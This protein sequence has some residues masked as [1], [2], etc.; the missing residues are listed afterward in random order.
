MAGKRCGQK[1]RG[2]DNKFCTSYEGGRGGEGEG[3]GDR[4]VERMVRGKDRGESMRRRRKM[5]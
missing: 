5:R 3:G 4:W 2:V 1:I